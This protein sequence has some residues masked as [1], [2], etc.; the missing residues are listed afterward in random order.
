MNIRFCTLATIILSS[1]AQSGLAYNKAAL[2]YFKAN[3]K[4]RGTAEADRDL[5]Y[6]TFFNAKLM[7]VNLSYANLIG[8]DFKGANLSNANLSNTS[9]GEFID[10]N[11]TGADLSKANI[12]DLSGSNLTDANLSKAGIS[13][14]SGVNFSGANLTGAGIGSCIGASFSGANLNEAV[15]CGDLTKAKFDNANLYKAKISTVAETADISFKGADLSSACITSYPNPY[16][17]GDIDFSDAIL[18][19]T[20]ITID[21]GG[22]SWRLLQRG[23]NEPFRAAREKGWNSFNFTGADL[24]GADLSGCP[25]KKAELKAK[26]ALGVDR[27]LSPAY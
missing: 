13:C 16:F 24:T 26:N 15:L 3:K 1:L 7:G 4:L 2:D 12:K 10:A 17:L 14:C 5:S 27:I 23:D 18:I 22:S 25:F 21:Y 9:Y 8:A 19:G 20:K 6:A 11:L